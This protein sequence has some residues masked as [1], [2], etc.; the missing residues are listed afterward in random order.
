MPTPESWLETTVT[1]ELMKLMK[2]LS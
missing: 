1:V 2:M